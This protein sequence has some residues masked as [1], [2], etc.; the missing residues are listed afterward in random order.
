MQ[1]GATAAEVGATT[2]EVG[3]TAA[4]V[5]ETKTVVV[6]RLVVFVG[7]GQIK[8]QQGVLSIVVQ[9]VFVSQQCIG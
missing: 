2:A 4:E 1:T 7:H 3:A 8:I 6:I 9:I 5:G